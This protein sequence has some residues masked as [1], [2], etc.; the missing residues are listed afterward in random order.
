MESRNYQKEI[1]NITRMLLSIQ[2]RNSSPVQ[3]V[4]K[5][6][7][8]TCGLSDVFNTLGIRNALPTCLTSVNARHRVGPVGL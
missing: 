2:A 7:P 3:H 8:P 6:S 5:V 4:R 1:E